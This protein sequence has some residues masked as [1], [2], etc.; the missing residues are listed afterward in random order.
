MTISGAK[1]DRGEAAQRDLGTRPSSDGRPIVATA[2]SKSST[3]ATCS[4]MLSPRSSYT[5]IR[6]AKMHPCR[7]GAAGVV[8]PRRKL[9]LVSLEPASPTVPAAT[10][11]DHQ[12]DEDDQKRSVVHLCLLVANPGRIV[13]VSAPPHGACGK[14]RPVASHGGLGRA[15]GSCSDS[16]Q[17]VIGKLTLGK[18][19]SGG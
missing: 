4:T 11:K 7:H 12:D 17:R 2:V 16:T 19:M 8:K 13:P 14:S 1:D 3:P 18:F 9:P 5:C 6:K 15:Y 10:E